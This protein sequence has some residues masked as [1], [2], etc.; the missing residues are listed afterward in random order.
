V[1]VPA[2]A[3][4]REM[5]KKLV[6]PAVAGA[7]A[8]IA[9]LFDPD[10]G[11]RRRAITKDRTAAALRTVTRRTGQRARY[12]EG[13]VHGAARKVQP[14]RT[15]RM[16]DDTTIKH[17]IESEVL[18]DYD[19]ANVNV[20]VD[21]GVAFLRGELRRPDQIS[22]LERDVSRVAGVRSVQNLVHTPR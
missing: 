4:E 2:R 17:K 11:R 16:H 7:G 10:N 9:Y 14:D 5:N 13:H 6:V 18:R 19:A 20:N 8:A 21:D 15:D 12:I 3:K 1:I 22:S